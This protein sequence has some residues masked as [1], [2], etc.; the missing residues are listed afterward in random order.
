MIATGISA[1]GNNNLVLHCMPMFFCLVMTEYNA[2]YHRLLTKKNGDMLLVKKSLLIC[3]LSLSPKF[4]W[5]IFGKFGVMRL[6]GNAMATHVQRY[7][8]H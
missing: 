7:K 3:M 4:I 8:R 1:T 5:I 2:L 6:F